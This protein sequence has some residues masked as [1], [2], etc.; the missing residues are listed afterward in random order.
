MLLERQMMSSL[1][2]AFADAAAAILLRLATRRFAFHVVFAM[3]HAQHAYAPRLP[4]H[5][6][7][8]FAN[9]TLR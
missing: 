1:I 5:V 2:I 9:I 6:D 4:R 7:D 3:T 8:D